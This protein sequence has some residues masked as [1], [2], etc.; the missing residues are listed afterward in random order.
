MLVLIGL[1]PR[2]MQNIQTQAPPTASISMQYIMKGTATVSLLLI[3][4]SR[5][6]ICHQTLGWG[7]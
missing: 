2:H 7:C 1:M 4:S 6:V 5:K 3:P